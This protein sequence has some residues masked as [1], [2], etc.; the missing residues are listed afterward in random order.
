MTR[1]FGLAV[2]TAATLLMTP[3]A[4]ADIMRYVADL[5]G[6]AE[7]PP[8]ASPGTGFAVVDFDN[9]AH[10]LHVQ[11]SFSRANNTGAA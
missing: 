2:I 5:S 10:T 9:A 6:P 8:N 7:S 3:P 11:I 1:L 4:R